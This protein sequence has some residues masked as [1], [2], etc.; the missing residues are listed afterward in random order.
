M[1]S[2]TT[3]SKN[4]CTQINFPSLVLVYL[5]FVSGAVRVTNAG[6]TVTWG[7]YNWLGIG[8]LGGIDAIQ[9]GAALQMYGCSLTLTGI[10]PELIAEGLTPSDYQGRTAT[11]YLAPLTEHYAFIADPVVVFKGRMDVADIEL[12][13]TATISMTVESRLVDWERPRTRRYNHEDQ[14]AAHPGDM[15]MQYVDQVVSMDLKWG[16]A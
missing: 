12:G 5:D 3:A 2:M 13:E 8:N 11:I 14:I 1:R 9:E 15:G 10:P 6:Y 4:A 16:R 7:G